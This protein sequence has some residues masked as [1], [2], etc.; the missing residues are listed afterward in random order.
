M[1]RMKL[2]LVLQAR[3]SAT[4]D[5]EAGIATALIRVSDQPGP[6]TVT[7]TASGL[8]TDDASITSY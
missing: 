7:A 4:V 6:I 8:T 1:R 5:A 3:R 2:H